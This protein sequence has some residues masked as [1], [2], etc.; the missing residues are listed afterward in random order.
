MKLGI[1]ISNIHNNIFC[2]GINQNIIFLYEFYNK[3]EI[4]CYL[5]SNEHSDKYKVK[6]NNKND[7]LEFDK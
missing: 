5:I 3:N 6:L 4:D 7:L 2:N 1:T